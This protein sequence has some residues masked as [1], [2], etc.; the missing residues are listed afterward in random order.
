MQV[1][2]YEQPTKED[3]EHFGVKGMKWGVRRIDRAIK[4]DTKLRRKQNQE[5]G[6]MLQGSS[7]N[8]HRYLKLGAKRAATVKKLEALVE[9]YGNEPTSSKR[10]QEAVSA[11][12]EY[13]KS[14]S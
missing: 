13:L 1:S 14:I 9:K 11:G 10:V 4:R 7:K 5:F 6:R 12:K 8:M 3:L 2:F